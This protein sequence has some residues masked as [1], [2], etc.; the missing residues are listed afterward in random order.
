MD[1][2]LAPLCVLLKMPLSADSL[3]RE[4]NKDGYSLTREEYKDGVSEC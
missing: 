4:E 1:R 3:T 2:L